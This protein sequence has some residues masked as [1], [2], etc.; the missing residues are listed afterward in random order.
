MLCARTPL[1]LTYGEEASAISNGASVS[2]NWTIRAEQAWGW[3][4]M[5]P[6]WTH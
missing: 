5:W 4:A 6:V 2:L 1:T 3:G